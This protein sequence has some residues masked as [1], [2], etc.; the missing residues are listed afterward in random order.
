MKKR[1]QMS[2]TTIYNPLEMMERILGNTNPVIQSRGHF[3]D[4]K[5]N[6]Y[7]LELPVAGFTQKDI[8]VEVDGNLLVI[9]GEDNES[10]WTDDFVKKFKLPAGADPDSVS[11][12]I[13][14]GILKITISKKK[15]SIPKKIKIS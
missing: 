11:A 10:Y 14:D 9:N 5:D 4:E 15:E 13:S 8:S 12:K 7:L 1:N 6:E 3:V 2:R